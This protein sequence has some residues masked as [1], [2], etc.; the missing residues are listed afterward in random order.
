MKGTFLAF[1]HRDKYF[2]IPQFLIFLIYIEIHTNDNYIAALQID[3][4]L[5]STIRRNFKNGEFDLY[6][7]SF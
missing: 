7:I 5:R 3:H 4:I 6:D 1:F 2:L